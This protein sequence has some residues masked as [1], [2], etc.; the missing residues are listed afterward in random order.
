MAF[1][2][3]RSRVRFPH[4]FAQL[5]EHL[6]QEPRLDHRLRFRKTPQTDRARAHLPLHPPLMARLAQATHRP[7]DGVEQPEQEQT[8]VIGVTHSPLGIDPRRNQRMRSL[9]LGQSALKLLEQTPPP[10]LA[11]GQTRARWWPLPC[12]VR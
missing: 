8:Q 7:H 3:A 11:L 10:E 6:R 9:R 2:R 1:I 4:L 5:G 12:H